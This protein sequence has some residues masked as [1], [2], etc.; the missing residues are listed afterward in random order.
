MEQD[1][2][3]HIAKKALLRSVQDIKTIEEVNELRQIITEYYANKAT[4]AMDELWEKG[5]WS[6]Q[7]NRD[8]LNQ[9]LR[10]PYK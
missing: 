4:K 2:E 8:I 1:Y 5:I 9:H 3:L 10:T 6:E 7:K